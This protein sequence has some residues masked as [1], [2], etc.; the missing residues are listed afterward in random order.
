M[1]NFN[2]Q[3]LGYKEY[4][5]SGVALLEFALVLPVTM[6]ILLATLEY[7]HLIGRHDET[8]FLT[9]VIGQKAVMDC[10]DN[11]LLNDPAAD[12]VTLCLSQRVG[13]ALRASLNASLP[14]ANEVVSVY[15]YDSTT[16]SARLRGFRVLNRQIPACSDGLD[17]DADG[18]IDF[19][20]DSGCATQY[21][22]LEDPDNLY[23]SRYTEARV[24]AELSS[25]LAAAGN[26][27]IAEIQNAEPF[28]FGNYLPW[29][30]T[31]RSGFYAVSIF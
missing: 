26:L 22:D 17:N 21:S 7:T 2:L 10:L 20:A 19:G 23:P 6:L 28:L 13:N 31:N 18:A 9:Q 29:A 16:N 3:H 30:S 12:A 14:S 15:V 11:T 8:A 25:E 4:R 27:V 1:N 24:N 5:E